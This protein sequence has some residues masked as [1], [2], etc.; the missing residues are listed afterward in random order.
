MASGGIDEAAILGTSSSN[1]NS[2]KI[3]RY[4]SF[5]KHR[6]DQIFLKR[7][8]DIIICI[9]MLVL[10]LPLM[11]VLG[12]LIKIDSPGPVLFTDYRLGRF[13]AGFSCY[14][15]RTMYLENIDM[16]QKHWQSNPECKEEWKR[17]GKLK[18]NDPRVTR[19][20]KWLRKSSLDE[21]PQLF[22]V[23]KGEM[24][25]V[26]PRPYLIAEQAA[27]GQ[28][29]DIILSVYPGVT[30][31]WQVSGRNELEFAERLQIDFKYVHQ[32]SCWLDT[33]ILLRTIIAIIS[34][35]GAY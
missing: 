17:Y 10:A 18:R 21:L 35:K 16:L 23:L 13:G 15:L 12:L 20:G 3:S 4:E 2:L 11:L 24:S 30:G 26:G 28:F 1:E 14:K 34:R 6:P 29:A 32:R 19:C 33:W 9:C 27:M 22:N 31:L 7:L 8:L 5:S 25:L